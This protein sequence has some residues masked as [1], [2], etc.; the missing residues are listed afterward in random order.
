MSGNESASVVSGITGELQGPALQLAEF[1]RRMVLPFN[2]IAG[3]VGLVFD[4]EAV[5]RRLIEEG[6]E[7]LVLTDPEIMRPI[8][9][10][11]SIWNAL[12]GN[13]FPQRFEFAKGAD[14]RS[15]SQLKGLPHIKTVDQLIH[16]M[17]SEEFPI[18]HAVTRN[19]VRHASFLRMLIL[20]P[21]FTTELV[22]QR[23]GG[24]STWQEH[25][26]VAEDLEAPIFVAYQLMSRLTDRSDLGVMNDD[27]TIDDSSLCI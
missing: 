18:A 17:S 9:E 6:R 25:A 20:F 13:N 22:V 12:V 24:V 16:I 8:E 5:N 27:G 4:T 2:Q 3:E 10:P 21:E 15:L 7:D 1:C 23:S 19:A 11:S 14:E 26:R